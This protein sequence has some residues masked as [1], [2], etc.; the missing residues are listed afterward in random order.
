MGLLQI[1]EMVLNTLL[2][3]L[4]KDKAKE[5]IDGLIDKLEDAVV[6]SAGKWDDVLV[7][8]VLKKLRDTFDI[9]DNDVTS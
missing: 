9:P 7:L 8:P 3:L 1:I 4:P 6:K 2:A 5:A